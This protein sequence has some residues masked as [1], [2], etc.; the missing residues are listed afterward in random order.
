MQY[1]N[2]A[3][4]SFPTQVLSILSIKRVKVSDTDIFINDISY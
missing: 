1:Y 4:K 3:V 2:I